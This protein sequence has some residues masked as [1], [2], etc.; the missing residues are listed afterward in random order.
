MA[1]TSIGAPGVI[2]PD[3]TVQAS[4]ANTNVVT[5]IY[6]AS[7]PWTKPATLKAVK[8][9]MVAGGGSGAGSQPG[10]GA[11]GGSGGNGGIL[12]GYAQAPAIPGSLTITVGTGGPAPAANTAGTTGG[13]SSFG[14]VFSITGGAGG[15]TL[16]PGSTPGNNGAAGGSYAI[17]STATA[18]SLQLTSPTPNPVQQF[19]N[20]GPTTSPF[21]ATG[22]GM[23]GAGSNNSAGTGGGSGTSGFM[24]VEEFY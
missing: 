16:N 19:G 4:A 2:F 23:G 7:S 22:Y 5:R 3:A 11:S 21:N 14:A 8:V 18:S 24:I 15:G 20:R 9:T 13:T 6:S 1:T 12:W 17:T 10:S